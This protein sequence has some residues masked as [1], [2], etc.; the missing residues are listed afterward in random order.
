MFKKICASLL[1]LTMSC[2]APGAERDYTREA[3]L[4]PPD[5]DHPVDVNTDYTL[6]LSESIGY[7][8][9]KAGKHAD[10][11]AFTRAGK[12]VATLWL[13]SAIS[14]WSHEMA[15]AYNVPLEESRGWELEGGKNNA[16]FPKVDFKGGTT[17]LDNDLASVVGGLN[18]SESN[19]RELWNRTDTITLDRAMAFLAFKLDDSTYN[20]R[21]AHDEDDEFFRIRFFN[22]IPGENEYLYAP[23]I[24]REATTND[25]NKTGVIFEY[26]G[27]PLG[28]GSKEIERRARV[29]DLATARTWESLWAVGKYL[30]TGQRT[31]KP[32]EF[33]IADHKFVPPNVGSYLTPRGVFYNADFGVD[34][35]R[36]SVGR[37]VDFPDWRIGVG[38]GEREVGGFSVA[39]FGAFNY[40]NGE[41]GFTAGTDIVFELGKNASLV[42]TL[43]RSEDDI[44]ENI[45][46][47]VKDGT[48]VQAGLRV[49]W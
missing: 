31:I 38:L 14:Y 30:A 17:T 16:G 29:A 15:H 20:I 34:G 33:D 28:H 25:L 23:T 41:R 11:Y 37:N 32:L 49:K 9:E 26:L 19:A 21:A 27:L 24:P 12:A 10:K 46:K 44:I 6:A 1:A 8:G 35:N 43:Q 36:V 3:R 42:F 40:I 7:L 18:Q 2:A 22:S 13:H 45:V 5:L 47:V 4:R 48:G 39:P